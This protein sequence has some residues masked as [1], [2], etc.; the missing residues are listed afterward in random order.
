[1]DKDFTD[2]AK[3]L[4][5]NPEQ[6]EEILDSLETK[7][8]LNPLIK[9]LNHARR[10]P[11]DIFGDEIDCEKYISD[12]SSVMDIV[13]SRMDKENFISRDYQG[14]D[15]TTRHKMISLYDFDCVDL[16]T[17]LAY[18]PEQLDKIVEA[19]DMDFSGWNAL[20]E[21]MSDIVSAPDEYFW[22]AN[23]TSAIVNN[24]SK[25]LPRV[26]E[27]SRQKNSFIRKDKH[28]VANE[29]SV[30]SEKTIIEREN[31]EH[32]KID[33]IRVG[34]LETKIKYEDGYEFEV[35][36]FSLFGKNKDA[37]EKCTDPRFEQ[38]GELSNYEATIGSTY[39]SYAVSTGRAD[40][41]SYSPK[42]FV[43]YIGLDMNIVSLLAYAGDVSGSKEANE[44][45]YQL[46]QAY[47][48]VN[49]A[50]EMQKEDQKLLSDVLTFDLDGIQNVTLQQVNNDGMDLSK[51]EF[52]SI[53]DEIANSALICRTSES[54][55]VINANEVEEMV[56]LQE[57]SK[58]KG[59]LSKFRQYIKEIKD[60]LFNRD[61]EGR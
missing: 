6:I 10:F 30:D 15:G 52:V 35:G 32:G 26:S 21:V 3:Q 31:K 50:D 60:K 48:R 43:D 7:M 16:G 27:L 42:D 25:V 37:S 55:K 29:E 13:L 36:T 19:N 41:E 53:K 34:A 38:Y 4:V 5:L 45:V 56:S 58:I 14:M 61:T 17:I 24:V 20:D 22:E 1:M 2:I 44:Q 54:A 46:L 9:E 39:G 49:G 40:S 47:R 23:D 18:N 28:V 12:I 33:S 57:T 8:E 11:R 51:D 59:A